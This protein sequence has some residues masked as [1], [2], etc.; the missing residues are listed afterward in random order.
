MSTDY[1]Y[2][3]LYD[4]QRFILNKSGT[5]LVTIGIQPGVTNFKR[6]IKLQSS[7]LKPYSLI[8]DENQLLLLF[9]LLKEVPD[10]KHTQFAY[11]TN[12][13]TEEDMRN[14]SIQLKT[15]K[16]GKDIMK[17]LMP[18]DQ[19]MFFGKVSLQKLLD[20]EPLIL[21]AYEGLNTEYCKELYDTFVELCLEADYPDRNFEDIIRDSLLQKAMSSW[22]ERTFYTQMY[23][24]F[25]DFAVA[26][27]AQLKN[28]QK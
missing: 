25:A 2:G 19:Y 26:H 11:S 14:A 24:N 3:R 22:N 13:S 5:K 23:I 10:I 28:E 17:I 21:Q 4:E 20:F 9:N 16:L 12:M 8:L 6:Q 18:D 15:S 1:T 7:G 27:I